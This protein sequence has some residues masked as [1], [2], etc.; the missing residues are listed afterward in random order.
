MIYKRFV[1]PVFILYYAICLQAK[2]YKVYLYFPE[3]QKLPYGYTLK[4]FYV[5]HNFFLIDMQSI[6]KGLGGEILPIGLHH[7]LRPFLKP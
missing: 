6:S 3:C 2:T 7:N 4:Y 5:I 1:L